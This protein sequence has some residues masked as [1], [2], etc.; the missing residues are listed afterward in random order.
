MNRDAWQPLLDRL[1]ERREAARAMGGA[2]K[3]AKRAE[4]GRATA[5]GTI[6]RLADP[7]T[8]TEFGELAGTDVPADAFVA[9][10]A[11]I[12]GRPVFIGAED[13]SVAGGSIGTA[14]ATKRARL[15]ELAGRER[16]PLILVL[17]GAG[18][19]ATNALQPHRPA[20]NDLQGLADLAQVV[21]IATIVIGPSAGHGALAAPLSDYCVL[22]SG[23]G[24]LF[25]AGPPLVAAASGEQVSVAE[26]GGPEVHLANGLAHAEAPDVAAAGQRV[27]RWLS[28]LPP[29]AGE[30]PPREFTGSDLGPRSTD[31]LLDL[32]PVDPRTPYDMAEV[33]AEVCDA[34]SVFDWQPGYG[35]SLLCA[36]ARLGGHTVA[37]VANQPR[38][39]AGSL[40]V[41]AAEKGARFLEFCGAFGLPVLFLTDNPGV[42][43]GS[44]SERAGILRASARMFGAQRRLRAPKLQVTIRKAF[45]FGSSVMAA[46]PF[47]H[48]SVSLALPTAT[49]GGIPAK[50]GGETAKEDDATREALAANES[51]G[52]WRGASVGTWDDIVDPREL[53]NALL[54]VLTRGEGA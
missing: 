36:L 28:Y 41:A 50:V 19:R 30:A 35:P 29:S 48:Q 3:L 44:A 43:A 20:P 45:G 13:G 16:R 22:V 12:D 9:G 32:I 6:E 21:P 37:V 25:T 51:A 54:A 10:W 2:E 15:I 5:R 42:L 38:V 4:R 17:D 47:D 49:L 8:F 33:I 7:G 23:H 46:N 40:D 52:P 1:A 11:S 14:G 18:H 53:R 24:V 27:R 34:G 39:L 31:A 26:L